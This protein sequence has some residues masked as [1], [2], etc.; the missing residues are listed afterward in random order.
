MK[1]FEVV[2]YP[3]ENKLVQ[4]LKKAEK[5]LFIA[6]PFIK[7]YGIEIILDNAKVKVLKILTNLDAANITGLGFDIESLLRLWSRFEVSIASLGKLH[8]KAYIADDKIAFLT[9]ANLT[10]SG[11]KENYEYGV[12]LQD[13][14]FVSVILDDMNKYFNLGNVFDREIIKSIINDVNDI[15]RLK[16]KIEKNI[17]LKNLNISLKQKEDNLQTKILQNRI[18]GKTIN[19]I[20]ADTMKY[21]L[22]TK[23]PLSTKELHPFIQNIHPDI[24]DD[25]IDRVI[26]GQHFGKKWKHLARNA[27]QYLKRNG[28]ISLEKGK[29]CLVR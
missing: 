15:R 28:I 20:F 22:E 4:L 23:G 7:D 16:Q 29:W 27:Q 17:E 1:S 13:R 21:L 25:T 12:I 5:N 11:L 24:C 10:R 19:G 14:E 2:Q 3:I 6:T 8:A 26:D 18:K 9:S